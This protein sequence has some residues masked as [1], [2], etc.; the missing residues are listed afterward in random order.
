MFSSSIVSSTVIVGWLCLIVMCLFIMIY[1]VLVDF[2]SLSV[3]FGVAKV[4]AKIVQMS[5]MKKK[6]A[7]FFFISECSLSYEKI[8]QASGITKQNTQFLFFIP[9][10]RLSFEK[11]M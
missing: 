3:Y 8:V 6:Y 11:K 1:F 9:A 7:V 10:R 5:E 2:F 4:T